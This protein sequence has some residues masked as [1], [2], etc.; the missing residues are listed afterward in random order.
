[1]MT[2]LAWIAVGA[3]AGATIGAALGVMATRGHFTRWRRLA[4]PP[5]SA[6]SLAITARAGWP[7]RHRVVVVGDGGSE[8]TCD[9]SICREI[10]S[11]EELIP[12]VSAYCSESSSAFS[13]FANDPTGIVQCMAVETEFIE[14]GVTE[15]VVLTEDGAAWRWQ[16]TWYALEVLLLP[17][18]IVTCGA[19][20]GIAGAFAGRR[21][22]RQERLLPMQG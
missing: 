20:G 3:V 5:Q 1:M 18:M 10:N 9:E 4:D 12:Q 17:A 21:R 2:R 14:S 19:I 13:P 22:R 7:Y 8:F 6:V 11:S 16:N 15:V